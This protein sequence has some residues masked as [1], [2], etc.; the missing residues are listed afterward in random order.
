MGRTS[1][2]PKRL[3]PMLATLTDA[4]FDDPAWIFEDKYDGFRMI[5][6]IK[7][8]KVALYSRN[9][10]IISHSYIEVAKALE[11]V[12]SDAVIDGELV[13]LGRDGVSHFQ[14][15]QNALRHEAKL[16]YCAFDLMFENGEDLRKL[17]LIERKK[18]LKAILP[19]DKLIAFS[20]HRKANGNEFFAQAERKGLEGI[21]AK[22]ADSAYASGGRTSDWLKV[23]TAKRQ[24]VVI[25]G[26]TAPRRTRPFF[27]ALVLAVRE[28]A[29]W[30]YIGHVGT[31]FTH[32][33]LGELHGKLMKL[34]AAT[35][36]FPARVKDEGVT[37]WVKPSLVAEVKFAEWTSKGELRQPVY[38][39]LRDDKQA[40]DVV[41][42]R[43]RGRA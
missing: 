5:A 43:E 10:K 27:G 30:R 13:A 36:P 24:E 41:R 2:L 42:E 37:T 8:G 31:G 9:G 25:A 38:L 14:L 12:K 40:M 6:E 11:G 16:L 19:R 3:Q 18:R 34:R 35:S 22:R 20:R 17:P 23:K 15:L 39:G 1:T 4:P 29:A 7:R 26:F 32:K 28:E 21:M 33:T